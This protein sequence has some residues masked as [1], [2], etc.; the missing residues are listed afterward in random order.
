MEIGHGIYSAVILLIPLIQEGLSSVTS[1]NMCTKLVKLVQVRLTDR[2]D[3]TIAVD[4]DVKPQ[5]K[6]THKTLEV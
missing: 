1:E 2:L 4:C 6:Q 3:M 5:T